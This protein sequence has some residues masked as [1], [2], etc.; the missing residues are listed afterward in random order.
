MS[1]FGI[2]F[3]RYSWARV[4]G[5]TALGT[6]L[7]ITVAIAID[8]YS[9]GTGEWRWGGINNVVIPLIL[10]PPLFFYLLSKLRELAIAHR[11]LINVAS[12]DSL[13][14]CLNRRAFSEMV[15][16]YFEKVRDEET[17]ETGALLLVDVDHFKSVNDEFGHDRGDEVLKNIAATMKANIR[18]IDLVGRLGGEEFGI[19]LPGASAERVEAIAERVRLSVYQSNILPD[20]RHVSISVGGAVFDQPTRFQLLYK[21]AD[22]LMYYAKQQGRNRLQISAFSGTSPTEILARV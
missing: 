14:N 3:S 4:Y 22:Q 6:L 13:T 21:F 8:S 19:F 7:C 9:P 1:I 12:T 10:A 5:L 11:E 18:E 17:K 16:G 20:G 15:D 2:D